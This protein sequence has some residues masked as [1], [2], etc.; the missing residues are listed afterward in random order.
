MTDGPGG[1]HASAGVAFRDATPIL[2]VADFDAS[3]AYYVEALGFELAWQDGRFGLVRRGDAGLMLCQGSQGCSS[4]WL[5]IG[6]SDA[7]ALH[8]ELRSRGARIRHPPTN[9]PWRS[10]ELHVFDLDGHVLRLA[11]DAP[12]EGPLGEWLDE[13]GVRW[14]AHPD[15][16]WT[17]VPD[18]EGREPRDA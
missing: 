5:F 1:G 4:T 11:S 13:E 14:Q 12:A 18:P 2:R 17:R 3:V 16:S 10:R 15:G 7:D 8:D 6:V 9:Y